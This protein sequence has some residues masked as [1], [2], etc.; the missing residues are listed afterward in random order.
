VIERSTDAGATW[1][2]LTTGKSAVHELLSLSGVSVTQASVV[3]KA[4]ANCAIG[5]YS[6]FTG[7]QFWAPFTANLAGATY[8]DLSDP[9]RIHTSA[10][11]EA[12]PCAMVRQIAVRPTSTAVLCNGE[13][14]ERTAARATWVRVPV[15]GALAMAETTTGYTLAVGGGGV[16]GCPGISIQSLS[17][18][19]A[20]AKPTIVGCLAAETAPSDV[21]IDQ[22]GNILWLWSGGRVHI[23]QDGGATWNQ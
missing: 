2:P 17:S 22:A 8:V 13:M 12:A 15:S 10:G 11:L 4:N 7:G 16:V 6:S 3:G 18:P 20:S 9:A 1:Q 5:Y 23:S 19:I 21:A 14:F